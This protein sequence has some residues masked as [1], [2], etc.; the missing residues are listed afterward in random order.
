M[1]GAIGQI[2]AGIIGAI[3]QGETNRS[4]RGIAN[5]Q[6]QVNVK[7]AK[8]NREWQANQAHINRQFQ[9]QMSST[10][11]QRAVSDL[12]AAGLNPLLALG[13][14]AS[15][16]AGSM[17][18]GS[19]GQ[20]V[21]AT[22]ENELGGLAASAA[23][24]AQIALQTKDLKKK[25][26]QADAGIKNTEQSTKESIAREAKARMETEVISKDAYKAD[27]TNKLYKMVQ[28]VVD[29]AT[30]TDAKIRNYIKKNK[31]QKYKMKVQP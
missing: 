21:G 20:A 29:S 1:F 16:S 14:G 2:G 3:G 30:Q 5:M 12:K 28:P 19:Q 15:T 8:K 17:P 26:E 13:Q 11:H 25:I 27:I 10:S 4:N 23:S 6:T 31:F 7:E 9:E 24:A 18:G 22:V